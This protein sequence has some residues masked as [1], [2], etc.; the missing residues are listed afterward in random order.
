V[1]AD[2]PTATSLAREMTPSPVN[3]NAGASYARVLSN[4][5]E[6]DAER[7]RQSGGAGSDAPPPV[8]RSD[9]P[10]PVA[11]P[12]AGAMSLDDVTSP[13]AKSNLAAL[14]E[15]LGTDPATLLAQ[16]TSG[17]DI[18][19]RLSGGGEGG[20]GTTIAKSTM[21]GLAIDQYA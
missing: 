2:K 8:A 4:P 12:P 1:A 13:R 7:R 19:G 20:Y 10:P 5:I 9:A 18:R 16:L 6:A 14:A 17:Q 15:S 21:S 3:A 11:T